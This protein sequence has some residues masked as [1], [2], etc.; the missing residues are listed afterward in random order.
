MS[1]AWSQ[2]E[3]L[4]TCAICLDRY[5]NPKLL[6]CHHT[7]CQEP[8]LDGLVDYARRQIKC[9]ECRAEHRIPYNGVQTFPTNVTL[10][11]FLELHRG[12]TGEE[13][14][15]IPSMMERCG[16]CS[17]KS[18]VERCAHCDKKVCPECKEAHLDIIKREINR[19]NSQ[20]RRALNRL[21]ESVTE[22]EKNCE[23]L[24]QNKV[25][26]REEIEEIVRRFLKDIKERE[27]KLLHDLEEYVTTESKGLQ[28]LKEDLAVE[29]TNIASNCELIEKHVLEL[30]EPWTDVELVEYKDIFVKTLEFL[31]NFD[32]D[33]SDYTRK[34][35]FTPCTDL[36]VLRK[37]IVNFG[38]LKLPTPET[39]LNMSPLNQSSSMLSVPSG[40]S[41]AN[42]NAIM[43][44]QSDHRLAAQFAQRGG[45]DARRYLE[46]SGS[47]GQLSSTGTSDTERDARG[48][49]AT[50]PLSYAR[51]RNKEET[52]KYSRFAQGRDDRSRGGLDRDDDRYRRPSTIPDWPRPDDDDSKFKSR[53]L[54]DRAEEDPDEFLN[55]LTQGH[56]SV[57]FEEPDRT[58][59]PKVFDTLDAP[60][61]PLSG[62]VKLSDTAHL[63]TRLHELEIKMKQQEAERKENESLE[64]T[65]S[66]NTT[67]PSSLPPTTPRVAGIRPGGPARQLSED[68][69]DKQKKANQAAAAAASSTTTTTSTPLTTNSTSNSSPTVKTAPTT[70]SSDR[71]TTRRF[72]RD[73]DDHLPPTGRRETTV[74]APPAS[75]SI[76]DVDDDDDSAL[77]RYARRRKASLVAQEQAQQDLSSRQVS[78]TSTDTAVGDDEFEEGSVE[79]VPPPSVVIASSISSSTTAAKPPILPA[80]RHLPPRDDSFRNSNQDDDEDEDNEDNS[81]SS[82]TNDNNDNTNTN[83]NSSF[84]T[85]VTSSS[86]F[87]RRVSVTDQSST[88][89]PVTSIVT[90]NAPSSSYATS[91]LASRRH[92]AGISPLTTST[93]SSRSLLTR[94]PSIDRDSGSNNINNNNN[95]SEQQPS[96]SYTSSSSSSSWNSDRNNE[97]RSSLAGRD[98]TSSVS[99]VLSSLRRREGSPYMT[100]Q[101][102]VAIDKPYS[103]STRDYTTSLT[104]RY[105]SLRSRSPSTERD[106]NKIDTNPS[107][108]TRRTFD[109]DY[110][111]SSS[112][113]NTSSSGR[114][115]YERDITSPSS[116]MS[117]APRSLNRLTRSSTVG[118]I[119]SSNRTNRYSSDTADSSSSYR[120]YSRRS[121]PVASYS[122][123]LGT[124]SGT[125]SSSSSYSRRPPL[126]S[127]LTLTD[128]TSNV[129]S[130]VQECL[131]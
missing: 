59:I 10:V 13:P 102:T 9:P 51:S 54:R 8:C 7:Y 67:T 33:T 83:T 46:V 98:D 86:S 69:I 125:T 87:K 68:E 17:E 101:A 64:G 30:H 74:T 70:V 85:P 3:Q 12:I 82:N 40:L 96:S 89:S 122:S 20:V 16:V 84:C 62:V 6:P 45:Q 80:S 75:S 53:F 25:H 37:S 39:D 73:E 32:P 71:Y 2:L 115:R 42:A 50:S 110:T 114:N 119:L 104:D 105:S 78:S 11:R 28:K 66:K 31:R 34:I 24:L 60:R 106:L 15:P 19:I 35:R 38:E 109:R 126:T 49:R 124:S 61:G 23:K 93:S 41:A 108:P 91:S 44:S 128:A 26:I 92:S 36:D 90:S 56:R 29:A 76:P 123:G 77:A 100:R 94:A 65:G 72:G 121:S 118:D 117:S 116:S 18:S 79:S 27:S 88:S 113:Y 120:D 81:L 55:S 5:R 99:S 22:T 107:T 57:R 4:L 103:Y 58:E 43:R 21:T 52:M 63:M 48:E 111:S 127:S 14:E 131:T 47:R 112:R 97:R 129:M 1:G 95:S 130:I